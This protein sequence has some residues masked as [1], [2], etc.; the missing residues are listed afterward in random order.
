MTRLWCADAVV[1]VDPSLADMSRPR[2]HVGSF[3]LTAGD[4]APAPVFAI[5]RVRGLS[6]ERLVTDL[7]E[8]TVKLED[9][10]LLVDVA[11]GPFL[12]ELAL[13]LGFSVVTGRLGGVLIHATGLA[14]DGVSLIASGPSGH[15]KSTLSRL[16]G[17]GLRLL[18]DEIFQLFPDGRVGGT[19]FR[20]DF[21][22]VGTPGLTRA[23]YFVG[24]AK[25]PHEALEPATGAAAFA[26]AVS[27]CFEAQRFNLPRVETKRRLMAFLSS[28]Q[29]GT[30]AFRKDPAVGPFV[31]GLLA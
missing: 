28:V 30:L 10:R 8:A 9:H 11:E 24:L 16:R 6:G 31:E 22:N 3:E 21:D 5:E 13:R 29:L 1:S 19:P 12:G 23:K 15:G 14:R 20:S 25:A 7:G 17:P 18:S 4:H 2:V 27:Q 26:L